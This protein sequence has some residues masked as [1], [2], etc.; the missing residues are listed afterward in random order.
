[1]RWF[2]VVA[3]AVVGMV[4]AAF[5]LAGPSGEGARAYALVNPNGGSPVLVADRTSGFT[6][7]SVGPVGTGDYCLTPAPG[8][9]ISSTA[10]SA[11]ME[12]FLSDA[13]G[14]A[15]VRYPTAGPTCRPGQLEVKTW[16]V[17]T[18]SPSDQIAFTVNVP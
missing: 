3:V 9:N 16:D 1:M 7:V 10:A 18:L 4:G 6:E 14:V 15:S 5:A 2:V 11:S 8:V 13:I 12:A 17:S